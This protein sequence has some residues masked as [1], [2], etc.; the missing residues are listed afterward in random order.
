[1]KQANFLPDNRRLIFLVAALL[2]SATV[3]LVFSRIQTTAQTESPVRIMPLG[4]SLTGGDAQRNSYRRPLWHLLNDAGYAVDFV[5]SRQANSSGELPPDRDFDL[6]HEGHSGA[7]V[8]QILEERRDAIEAARP[9]IVLVLLGTND[10]I[11]E[12]SVESTA[13]E[14]GLLIDMLRDINPNVT[15]LLGQ[16]PDNIA[17]NNQR[18]PGLNTQIAALAETAD[19]PD[20]R[21]IV[22][23]LYT[24]FNPGSDTLDGLHPT[25]SGEHKLANR[26]YQA[27]VPVLDAIAAATQ[28]PSPSDTQTSSPTPTALPTDTPTATPTPTDTL[29]PTHTFTPTDTLMPTN[30]LTPSNTPTPVIG[31]GLLG[32]YFDD[33]ELAEPVLTRVDPQIEFLWGGQAP[34]PEIDGDTFSARWTGTVIPRYSE[35]YTFY[36]DADDGA[37]LWVDGELLIDDWEGSPGETSASITLE[38]GQHYDLRLEYFENYFNASVFLLWSSE[39]EPKT[40]IPQSQLYPPQGAEATDEA[41][42]DSGNIPDGIRVS[43]TSCGGAAQQG[44]ALTRRDTLPL[45]FTSEGR[46]VTGMRFCDLDIPRGATILYA[47]LELTAAETGASSLALNVAFE[48]APDSVSFGNGYGPEARPTTSGIYWDIS[49]WVMLER[50]TSPDLTGALQRVLNRED[51]QPR[52]DVSVLMWGIWGNGSRLTYL[53]YPDESAELHIVYAPESGTHTPTPRPTQTPTPSERVEA[54]DT[55]PPATATAMPPPPTEAPTGDTFDPTATLEPT[56]IPPSD[57]PEPTEAPPT[58]TP[59]PTE[60]PPT[61]TPDDTE[62]PGNGD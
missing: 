23:D 18:I 29:T 17:P 4:D 61:D 59:A 60:I 38:A 22:V 45:G 34:A 8:D 54:T 56:P 31:R 15:V 24:G 50:Y 57:T 3:S 51:W 11:Q 52:G 20:S 58:D 35:E 55:P 44:E 62:E 41:T 19:K 39:S 26:W 25:L 16:L 1:M 9:D 10:I 48:D 30:T 6:D 36:V 13:F 42:K 27:L 14:L 28:L 33:V 37:R 2:F 53:N 12:Q 46:W 43:L 47:A 32:E 49:N 5:G 40:V 7:R 21:V